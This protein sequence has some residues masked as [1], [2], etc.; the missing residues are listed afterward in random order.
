MNFSLSAFGTT[1]ITGID[2]VFQLRLPKLQ[3]LLPRSSHRVTLCEIG[4]FQNVFL[5]PLSKTSS[6]AWFDESTI[7]LI[8]LYLFINLVALGLS[9][10]RRAP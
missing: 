8:Y 5:L 9:C 2:S 1:S 3:E 7:K 6:E 10:G 4:T